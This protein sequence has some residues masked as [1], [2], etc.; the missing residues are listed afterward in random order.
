MEAAPAK[1]ID[2]ALLTLWDG[3]AFCIRPYSWRCFFGL[4]GD[5]HRQSIQPSHANWGSAMPLSV[6]R[7]CGR[8]IRADALYCPSCGAING[9]D[10]NATESLG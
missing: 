5:G 2:E 9:V 4:P 3:V 6:C 1:S 7:T 10:E 8:A